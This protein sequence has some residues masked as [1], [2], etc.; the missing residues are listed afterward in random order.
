M[1]FNLVC[2]HLVIEAWQSRGGRGGV[3]RCEMLRDEMLTE[4][5]ELKDNQTTQYHRMY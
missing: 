5:E 1:N 4:L 3:R 2:R